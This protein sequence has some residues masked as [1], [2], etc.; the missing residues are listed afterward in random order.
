MKKLF[1][2]ILILMNVHAYENYD[3]CI[4]NSMT[5]VTSDIAA[6]EIKKSCR[7]LFPSV[8]KLDKT[9][10]VVSSKT[11]NNDNKLYQEKFCDNRGAG[12]Y[13]ADEVEIRKAVLDDNKY[14]YR[15]KTFFENCP[16][17]VSSGP[18]S[19]YKILNCTLNENGKIFNAKIMG[20]TKPQIFKA[21]L[22]IEKRL[23]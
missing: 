19:H 6:K 15:I 12:G 7:N 13:C 20:W 9:I 4:I 5:G 16:V 2:C 21:T 10:T 14:E 18:K 17:G 8:W 22:T 23:K 3:E 1:F 11:K